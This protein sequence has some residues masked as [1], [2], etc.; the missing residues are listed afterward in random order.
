MKRRLLGLGLTLLSACVCLAGCETLR[1]ATRSK[2]DGP[3]QGERVADKVEGVKSEPSKGFF[4]S[5]RLS[6]AMSNEGR[7]IERDLGI[8]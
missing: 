1:Q 4:Q 8:H 6:G 2:A 7:E 3:D 5:S